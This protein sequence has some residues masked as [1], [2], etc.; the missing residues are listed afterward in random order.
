MWLCTDSVPPKWPIL[1]DLLSDL[2]TI[3][4]PINNKVQGSRLKDFCGI[5]EHQIQD[6]K[7][8]HEVFYLFFFYLA[9]M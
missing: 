5:C 2:E 1:S 8:E 9:N 3:Q 4:T 6:N 7:G